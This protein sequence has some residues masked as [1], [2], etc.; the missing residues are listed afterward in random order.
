MR[1]VI[2]TGAILGLLM[3]AFA[4]PAA[5]A[6]TTHQTEEVNWHAQQAPLGNVGEVDGAGARLVRNDNGISFQ[7]HGADLDPGSAYTLWLVVVNNPDACAADPCSAPEIINNPAT[8]AQVGWA[9][10]GLAGGSGKLTL[11]GSAKTGALSGWLADRSLGDPYGAEVH[12]VLNS[13]GP[14][15]PDM[16][17]GMIKTYRGGCSDASPFPAVFPP[18]A[19]A[20]GEVGP[21]ECRLTQVAVFQP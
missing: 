18:N 19:I 6:A 10:G 11:A 4:I 17:P 13:H 3:A 15:I 5:F 12:L 9:A 21:N 20:D 7:F 14:M 2:T 8:D 1:R 16:M